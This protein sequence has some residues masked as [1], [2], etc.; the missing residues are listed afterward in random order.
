VRRPPAAPWLWFSLLTC[1]ALAGGLSLIHADEPLRL[2][3][4][5]PGDSKQIQVDADEIATWVEGK[6][7]I[8][9]LK[10]QVLVQHG[11]AQ[12][13]CDQ[14]FARIDLE[15]FE[16]Q[17][18]VHMDLIADGNVKLAKGSEK[19]EGPG[20]IIDLHTRGEFKL[21]AHKSKVS[22]QAKPDDPLYRRL[23]GMLAAPADKPKAPPVTN[24]VQQT[25]YQPSAPG[26]P[27]SSRPV[28]TPVQRPAPAPPDPPP[29]TAAPPLPELPPLPPGAG[30]PGTAPTT[31]GPPDAS[32]PGASGPPDPP[33][34]T[35]AR[36]PSAAI[37]SI[38]G[39]PFLAPVTPE[40]QFTITPRTSAG[41]KGPFT[42]IV[43]GERVYVIL[44]G[45]ILSVTGLDN[46][47]V[48][49]IEADSL[50]LWSRGD[51][52]MDAINFNSPDGKTRREFEFYMA[53]N[54]E[55]RE[56]NGKDVRTLRADEVYYDINRHVAIAVSADLQFKQPGVAEPI[57]FRA[58]E[59]EQT[60]ANSFKA[61]R[62]EVFSSKTPADPGL[63]VV[64]SE[65]TL[66]ERKVPRE[67]IF[68]RIF[69]NRTTG[70][71]ETE[72]QQMVRGDNVFL[73]LEDVPVFYLPFVQ[74]DARDPLGPIRGVSL[75]YNRIFGAQIGV[76]LNMFDLLAITPGPSDRWNLDVDY[77]SR[78]GPALG[79]TYDYMGTDPFGI[80]GKYTGHFNAYGIYD[81]GSDILGGA[82]NFA[83][84]EHP[85]W[86]GSVQW[87][88][89]VQGLPQGFSVQ[90]QLG[91]F[92][93]HNFFEQYHKLWYDQWINQET[94]LYVKQQRDNW[95]WSGLVQ[96]RIR[97]WVTETSQ[98]PAF[99]GHL[100]GES[101]FDLF[102]YNAQASAGYYQLMTSHDPQPPVSPTDKNNNTGRF[103]FAQELSL[104]FAAGPVKIVP[105]GVLDLTEYT[106]D[107]DNNSVGRVYGAGGVR[108]SM[109]F[110]RV[111]SDVDSLMF[112]LHELNH[113]I[114]LNANYYLAVTNEHYTRFAQLDRLN[115][116]VSDQA[117]R[118]L[119]AFQPLI[120]PAQ[121]TILANPLF[122]PQLYAIRRLVTNRVDTLDDVNVLQLDA[123][124]RLQTKRGYPGMEH[125]ID[126][127]TLDLSGSIFPQANRD[128]FGEH[129]GFL[130]YD[131]LWNVGDR[132]AV[133]STGLFDPETNGPRVWSISGSLN[134]P[135]RTFFALGFRSI[136]P[137]G[138]QAVTLAITEVF[139]AKYAMTAASVYDFGT[140]QAVSNA[141]AFTR[142]GSDITVSVGITYNAA[143]NA[144]GFNLVILPNLVAN[145]RKA[146]GLVG[147][148]VA[149]AGMLGSR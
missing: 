28:E 30:S 70:Q 45:V 130:E 62:A 68:G 2:S 58:D 9:L 37:P 20:A 39:Q 133:A 128:N 7:R 96:Q 92:S 52:G 42:Q 33:P 23:S 8:I 78:R 127:M 27:A 31:P 124:Q 32:P 76:S 99:E 87:Q 107:L 80:P 115:D 38:P 22:Q 5:L 4:N 21:N 117:L 50:T 10:G 79:T 140:N 83:D 75:G 97:N 71:P 64:F 85:F 122:D 73:K 61:V 120:L 26:Q 101:F 146:M 132:T 148:Q 60:G 16:Q 59:I 49:D 1:G 57:H 6:Y 129:F 36:G 144:V 69:T 91:L 105:Y 143:T 65:A 54:V 126:W 40:R 90:S 149:G 3:R 82:R 136:E 111:Y 134:R 46:S 118:D 47:G 35:H 56:Q 77:L 44:G 102:S 142:T 25:S 51:T 11:V 41:F 110:T 53:G 100:I 112:N 67:S 84:N 125:I 34:P 113:K 114:V 98:L 81:N 66:D 14:A 135:D 137:V 55:I 147:A 24:P 88:Q 95:A 145:T 74:G 89:M 104:P 15:R 141:L 131:Y 119:K 48:V 13:R 18:I 43:N 108:A 12:V 109:P 123:R 72:T 94:S 121:R 93:D 17:H 63:K 19:S 29:S 106:N 138:S 139:S 116:D 86:R 103:D